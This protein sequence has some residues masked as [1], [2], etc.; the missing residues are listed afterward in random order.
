MAAQAG[1]FICV[2]ILIE[3]YRSKECEARNNTEK[4]IKEER[5]KRGDIVY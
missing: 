5:V 3:E 4:M 1:I 2:N